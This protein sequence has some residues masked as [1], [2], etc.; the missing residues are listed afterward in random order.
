LFVNDLPLRQAL[1]R[2]G[3]GWAAAACTSFGEARGSAEVIRSF[4]IP[5]AS[6]PELRVFDRGGRRLD[7]VEF[8]PACSSLVSAMA[9][10]RRL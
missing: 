8:H 6:P 7:E 9:F 2:E 1:E 4:T 5:V 10:R 3:A